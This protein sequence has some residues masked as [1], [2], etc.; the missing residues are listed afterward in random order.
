MMGWFARSQGHTGVPFAP[1]YVYSQVDGGSDD[2][3]TPAQVLDVL[4][5][6]GIDTAAHYAQKHASPTLDWKHLPSAAEHAS[7]AANK[8]T[9]Y[10]TLYN[11]YA[12]PGQAAV[13]AI[14]QAVAS[15]RPVALAIAVYQRFMDAAGP[16]GL[17]TST[18]NLGNLLGYHEVLIV[19]YNS[20]GVRIQN[21]WGTYWGDAGYAT[22][23]WNYVAQHSYEAETIAG[24]SS[25]T[26]ATRP[27]VTSVSPST[28]SALGGQ[29][30]T[31][32]GTGLQ[33][34]IVSIS[35]NSM[36]P[37]TVS[38]DGKRLTFRA[39]AGAVG[40]SALRVSTPNGVSVGGPLIYRYAR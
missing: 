16:N 9:G 5:T 1:M 23:D 27:V 39:P 29:I 32:T 12:A 3:T 20:T 21:S 31:V 37:L 40:S 35:A 10:V 34:A 17:V 2:G 8:I 4:R 18:G 11:T 19:G 25:T 13:T 6:Q 14:K 28:G 38:A 7:A 36:T 24:F 26:K 30:V 15:G 33:S 22:L